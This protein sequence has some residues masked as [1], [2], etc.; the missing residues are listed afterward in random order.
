MLLENNRRSL[1]WYAISDKKYRACH[2]H[3]CNVRTFKS[4]ELHDG[5]RKLQAPDLIVFFSGRKK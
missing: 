3:F 1:Y 2:V 5:Y 4:R